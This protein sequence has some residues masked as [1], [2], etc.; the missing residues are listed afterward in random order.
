MDRNIFNWFCD[1]LFISYACVNPVRNYVRNYYIY[2]VI[3]NLS[4]FCMCTELSR[5]K[6]DLYVSTSI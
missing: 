5:F 6:L 1:L 4:R 2:R 3:E